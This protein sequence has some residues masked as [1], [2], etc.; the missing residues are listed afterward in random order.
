[1]SG[2]YDFLPNEIILNILVKQTKRKLIG[3]KNKG[4]Y[5]VKDS[6]VHVWNDVSDL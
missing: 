6:N 5:T 1:M 2:K 3:E 4:V